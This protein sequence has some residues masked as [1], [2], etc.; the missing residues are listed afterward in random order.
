MKDTLYLAWRYLVY[1]KYKTSVLVLAITLIVFIPT[2]LRVL[3]SQ[4]QERLASRAAATPLLVGAKGSPL[5]LVLNSLYA[6]AEVPETLRY[7]EVGRIASSG[8]AQ[9]IPLYVRFRAQEDP[10]VGATLDYFEFRGLRIAQGRQMTRLGDC[11][12]GAEVARRRGIGPGGSIVSS[13]ENVF[14]LAGVYPLKMR[15]T[16]VLAPSDSPDDEAIFADVKTAWLIDGLAHGHEDLSQPEAAPA[17]AEREG[18][19]ITA[20]ASLRQY[21]EVTADNIKSFHFHG[22]LQRYPITA[23]LAIPPDEKSATLLMGRYQ[24]AAQLNQIVRPLEVMTELLGTILT[25]ESF[26]VAAL[27]IVGVA[28]LATAALVF[29]LSLRLRR[30]E[31]ETMFKIGGSKRKILAVLASEMV[32]V[33]VVSVS[34][35]GTLTWV[36]AAFGSSVIRS[37]IVQ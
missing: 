14:D 17:V 19:R 8:L 33:L 1:H 36:T 15:I 29:L 30:R 35:A 37:F 34:M 12:L 7:S 22:D 20:N 31:M 21:N 32:V 13:P 10:I 5:E 23:V 26:V 11:V 2:G 27:I 28:T 6:G 3:V 4:S 24:D 18:S 25:I 16:G 9:P